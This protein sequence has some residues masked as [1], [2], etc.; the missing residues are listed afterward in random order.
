MS[1]NNLFLGSV[2]LLVGCASYSA[3][4]LPEPALDAMPSLAETDALVVGAEVITNPHREEELFGEDLGIVGV[5][6]VR[7]FIINRGPYVLSI[8]REN[9]LFYLPDGR[10]TESANPTKVSR[11]I[12]QCRTVNP[13]SIAGAF[14]LLGGITAIGMAK[15]ELEAEQE[16]S[17][18]YETKAL[19]N[20]ELQP[21]ESVNGVV[22]FEITNKTPHFTNARLSVLGKIANE[23]SATQ[24][25]LTF[26]GLRFPDFSCIE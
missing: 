11:L 24:V 16:R 6:P 10:H 23:E 12:T 14:G 7:V 25:D 19:D 15:A 18:D 26:S 2:L 21:N 22:F 17:S 8:S 20:V 13:D 9:I 1:C 3:R 5:I 4:E